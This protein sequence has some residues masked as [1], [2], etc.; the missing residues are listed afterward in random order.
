MKKN[1]TVIVLTGIMVL[2][3]ALSACHQK[4]QSVHEDY[5][6]LKEQ[7][8][9]VSSELDGL[10]VPW[11]MQYDDGNIWYD[12]QKGEIWKLE[13]KTGKAKRMVQV[14]DVFR[15]R[16]MG[17]LGIAVDHETDSI[18]VYLIYNR[19]TGTSGLD[20]STLSSRLVR[21]TYDAKKDTLLQPKTIL[22]WPANTSHN[23]ARIL[24]G[25]NNDL[26]LT[27]GD[28]EGDGMAQSTRTLNGKVLH[29]MKDGSIP[30]DNPFS[31]SYIWSYGHRN[32][33]GICFGPN[34][35][36]YA[37]EHGDAIED[38]VN[39]I[40]PKHNYGWPVVEGKL[41]LPSEIHKVDSMKITVTDPLI[42]WTPTIAPA[43]IVYYGNG[44]ITDFRNSL[45][46]VTLKGSALYVLHL[47][48]TGRKITGQDVYFK[49]FYGRLR[50]ITVDDEGQVYLGTSNRDWNPASGYPKPGDDHILKIAVADSNRIDQSLIRSALLQTKAMANNGQELFMNYCSSCHK[51]GGEGLP[52]SFPPLK[53]NPTLRENEKLVKTINEGTNGP[54]TIMGNSYNGNMPAFNFLTNAQMLALI[55]YLK[56]H[57]TTDNEM[58]IDDLGKLRNTVK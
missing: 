23:G 12:L 54:K 18:H 36:L 4:E 25:K 24:V 51:P 56:T 2:L 37:S 30:P 5:Y 10:D 16:T 20:T 27:T 31:N 41:D 26:Y 46:L 44:A 7:V 35:L 17:A 42:S 50:S 29:L 33:Q 43:S 22:Q 11:G 55:N 47:D 32:Q 9:R 39:L 14:P 48:A 52:G 45:L 34:G 13:L 19:R 1:L 38:E 8:V 53:N 21:Y 3:V 57:L 15:L 28:I 40:E 6:R 49:N 58:S